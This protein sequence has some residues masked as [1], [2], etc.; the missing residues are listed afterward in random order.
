[1]TRDSV[2]LND[3]SFILVDFSGNGLF[4]PRAYKLEIYWHDCTYVIDD[5][6]H[7]RLT[8]LEVRASPEPKKIDKIKPVE[9]PSIR[10]YNYYY[11]DLQIP[12]KYTGFLLVAEGFIQEFDLHE[13]SHDACRFEVVYE[14]EVLK[15]K[16]VAITDISDKIKAYREWVVQSKS[17]PAD[18]KGITSE[19]EIGE[20]V[21]NTFNERYSEENRLEK[22]RIFQYTGTI[23]IILW[24][25]VMPIMF[26]LLLWRIG[27]LFYIKNYSKKSDWKVQKAIK[28]LEEGTQALNK[29][30]KKI[31]KAFAELFLRFWLLVTFRK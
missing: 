27:T 29:L 22:G 11:E 7:L 20:W 2:S 17:N 25:A 4:D 13:A 24:L 5:Q 10:S 15:G 16:V 3:K 8:R 28:E 21:N 30:P 1:M 31:L 14:L 6:G 26:P 9:S 18:I 19:T 23:K 12:I